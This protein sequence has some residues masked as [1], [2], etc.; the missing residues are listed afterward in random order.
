ML[1]IYISPLEVVNACLVDIA[2]STYDIT[3]PIMPFE[4]QT[5]ID[6]LFNFLIF[7]YEFPDQISN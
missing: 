7:L 2:F 5:F 1:S 4:I 6:L 3:L